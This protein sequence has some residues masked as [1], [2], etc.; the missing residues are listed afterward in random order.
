M[1]LFSDSN[2]SIISTNNVANQASLLPTF[3]IKKCPLHIFKSEQ[4]T[5]EIKTEINGNIGVY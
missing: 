2:L 1:I 3:D 4:I 5:I